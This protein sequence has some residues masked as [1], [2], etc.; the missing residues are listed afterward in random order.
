MIRI[1]A[2][3]PHARYVPLVSTSL[4]H[5]WFLQL[6]H[7]TSIAYGPLAALMIVNRPFIGF[8]PEGLDRLLGLGHRW[9]LV[10]VPILSN[11][12]SASTSTSPRA[13]SS[14]LLAV[15]SV[16]QLHISKRDSS[17]LCLSNG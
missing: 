14:A 16:T 9:L 15:F 5:S 8:G 2:S 7:P 3:F 13:S 11:F 6:S 1:S 12:A 4:A 10:C 17:K